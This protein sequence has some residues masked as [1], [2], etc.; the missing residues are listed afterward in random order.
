MEKD[1]VCGMLIDPQSS[2]GQRD[3]KGVVYHFCSAG[4]LQ[5]FDAD[6]ERYV[7]AHGQ[8]DQSQAL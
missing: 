6:P 5:R 8:D 1:P 4:C 2:A 3:Y 7:I